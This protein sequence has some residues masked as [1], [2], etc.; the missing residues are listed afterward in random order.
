MNS[1]HIKIDLN[2]RKTKF[3]TILIKSEI[4]N[5]FF[6]SHYHTIWSF[7]TFFDHFL[8][9]LNRF[10]S[11]LI[12]F[13][14]FWSILIDFNRFW[15][16]LIKS[17]IRNSFF[18]SHCH[19]IWSFL[20]I[21]DHFWS[22]FIFFDRF[23]PFLNRFWS[24]S[25]DFDRFWLILIDFDRFLCVFSIENMF[26]FVIKNT[27]INVNMMIIYVKKS[28]ILINNQKKKSRLRRAPFRENP[29]VESK[30]STARCAGAQWR[31]K[32]RNYWK[33]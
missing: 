17:E 27:Q 3:F 8:P 20:I 9:F 23:L 31:E 10:W 15:S 21:F 16:I 28:L 1:L 11:I 30:S 14:R 29:W 18:S 13:D 24:I 6:S 22:F 26:F 7:F 25:I 4:R 33:S 5:L 12:D 2:H 19:M 32:I